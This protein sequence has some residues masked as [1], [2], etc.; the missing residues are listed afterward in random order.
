M[1]NLPKDYKILIEDADTLQFKKIDNV[2]EEVEKHWQLYEI[3]HTEKVIYLELIN[4]DPAIL[5]VTK[6]DL[7][8]PI[9]VVKNYN[10]AAKVLKVEPTHIYRAARRAGRPDVLEYNQ[11]ILIKI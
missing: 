7:E 9:A 11:Y 2:T 3:D 4:P 8:L 10:E 5:I 6:D 1:L